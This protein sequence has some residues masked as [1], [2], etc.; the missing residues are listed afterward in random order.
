MKRL[1]PLSVLLPVSLLAVLASC[2]P[3]SS[4]SA[5]TG[6]GTDRFRA[7]IDTA[8]NTRADYHLKNNGYGRV[9]GVTKVGLLKD[10]EYTNLDVTLVVGRDYRLVGVCDQ[11]CADLDM[12]LYNKSGS[13][14]ASDTSTDDIP[15][16]DVSPV[17]AGDYTLKVSMADC[18]N[19]RSGCYYG[20][21][22]LRK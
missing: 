1:N 6:S 10:G 13:L 17:A 14:V 22:L 5:S 18:N 8:L 4:S 20:V 7:Y 16:V 21:T 12:K 3:S 19:S 2:S 9:D 11:D 15:L